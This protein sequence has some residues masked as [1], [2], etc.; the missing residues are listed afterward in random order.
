MTQA[1]RWTVTV[2]QEGDDLILPMPQDMMDQQGWKIGDILT[3]HEVNDGSWELRKKSASV[4]Q[5]SIVPGKDQQLDCTNEA[6][7]I[8]ERK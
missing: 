8:T 5:I 2:Q 1:K 3:W 7:Q 6:T 4:A